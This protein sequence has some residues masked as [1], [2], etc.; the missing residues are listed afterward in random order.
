MRS[1]AC[2]EESRKAEKA[3]GEGA[4]EAGQQEDES[5]VEG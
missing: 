5:R 4:D 1:N 3:S 2:K